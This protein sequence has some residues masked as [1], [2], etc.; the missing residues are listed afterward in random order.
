LKETLGDS[1]GDILA[2]A[3]GVAKNIGNDLSI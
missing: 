2:A 1:A 3:T